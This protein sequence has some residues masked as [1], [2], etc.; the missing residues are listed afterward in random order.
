M[1][2]ITTLNGETFASYDVTI[3][4]IKGLHDMPAQKKEPNQFPDRDFSDVSTRQIDCQFQS[5][6]I[7]FECLICG[8]DWTDAKTKIDAFYSFLFYDGLRMLVCPDRST[9]GYMVRV[10]KTTLFEPFVYF[11]EDN[12]C[13]V[14]FKIVF[15]EPQPFNVQFSYFFPLGGHDVHLYFLIRDASVQP[16]IISTDQKYITVHC[17]N[18]ST[19]V[20]L[21]ETFF[22]F[23]DILGRVGAG[24]IFPIVITGEIDRITTLEISL[25]ENIDIIT[26][27]EKFLR[28]GTIDILIPN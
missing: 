15:E 27:G 9:R 20:N 10:S 8:T 28:N 5:R 13:V 23:E 21:Q 12:K 2:N 26:T 24:F 16:S 18:T 6:M 11:D 19:E 14:K 25:D 3:L 4:N 1:S 17:F 7:N 22:E